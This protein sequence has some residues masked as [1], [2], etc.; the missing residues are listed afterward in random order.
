[1]EA[2]IFVDSECDSREEF[3]ENYRLV[4]P[5]FPAHQAR[6][7]AIWLWLW[8][9]PLLPTILES[10]C[11]VDMESFATVSGHH[12]NMLRELEPDQLKWL[13]VT[14][15]EVQLLAQLGDPLRFPHT[16]CYISRIVEGY[17]TKVPA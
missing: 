7:R 1:M 10:F 3:M 14:W 15:L 11:V 12:I 8:M 9:S 2:R 5:V 16:D 13:Q 17:C 6:R 4:P